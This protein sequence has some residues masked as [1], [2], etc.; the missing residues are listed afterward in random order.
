M[1][2]LK[3]YWL[4]DDTVVAEFPSFE[5]ALVEWDQAGETIEIEHNG[6]TLSVDRVHVDICDAEEAGV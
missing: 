2:S 6:K 3:G 5:D 4:V 1:N